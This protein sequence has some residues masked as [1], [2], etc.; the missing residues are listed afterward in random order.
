MKGQ[1][2]IYTFI[3]KCVHLKNMS[4]H[5]M[6]FSFHND[7]GNMITSVLKQMCNELICLF[8]TKFKLMSSEIRGNGNKT[9]SEFDI[10]ERKDDEIRIYIEVHLLQVFCL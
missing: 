10:S 7:I 6:L 9:H 1:G 4:W 8:K 2:Q 5:I 3:L